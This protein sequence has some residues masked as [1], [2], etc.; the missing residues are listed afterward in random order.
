MVCYH[1]F[2]AVPPAPGQSRCHLS[3]G[4]GVTQIVASYEGTSYRAA[5]DGLEPFLTADGH[6]EVTREAR[7]ASARPAYGYHSAT[8]RHSAARPVEPA[9]C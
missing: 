5:H 9:T 3:C 1:S 2:S 4:Q 6:D 7:C 8:S